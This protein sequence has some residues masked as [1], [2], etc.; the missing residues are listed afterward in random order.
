MIMD[1]DPLSNSLCRYFIE[2]NTGITE[3]IDFVQ[4]KEGIG[5]IESFYGDTETDCP[6]ILLLDINMPVLSGWDFLDRFHML[7]DH[8][9]K[10][11][12][13]YIL[14]SSVNSADRERALA[15]SYVK[16]FLVKPL[17]LQMVHK[18]LADLSSCF[19]KEGNHV[20]GE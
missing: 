19:L 15:N 8:I 1:D 12:T 11:F 20:F 5:Y 16:D 18:I 13:I 3:V 9:K 2:K 14:T 17:T 7:G 4:P 6:T 10:Q